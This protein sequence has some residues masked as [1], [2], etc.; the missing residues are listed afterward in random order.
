MEEDENQPGTYSA[1]YTIAEGAHNGT[2]D[3]TV[4]IEGTEVSVPAT[5]ALIIDTVLPVITAHIGIGR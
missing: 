1:D 3:I 5:G 4:K 2:Y